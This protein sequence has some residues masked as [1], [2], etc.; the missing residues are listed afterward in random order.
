[1]G[2]KKQNDKPLGWDD[3]LPEDLKLRWQYW[4]EFP[5][6]ENVSASRCYHPR[7]FGPVSQNEIHAFVDASK[8]AIGTSVYLKQV[9]ERGETA[10][11]QT[12][13]VYRHILKPVRLGA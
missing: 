4:K 13:A 3:P 9:N 5:A 12:V 8:D 1:M 7:N 2:K 11:T 6:L 10:R